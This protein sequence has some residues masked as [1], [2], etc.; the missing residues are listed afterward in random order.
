M[1]TL[2]ERTSIHWLGGFGGMLPWGN[3]VKFE[4]L[5]GWK[6]IRNFS[7][8]T[9]LQ[10]DQYHNKDRHDGSETEKF[11]RYMTPPK[12]ANYLKVAR[13]KLPTSG[14]WPPHQNRP[15][16]LT[17]NKRPAPYFVLKIRHFCHRSGPCCFQTPNKFSGLFSIILIF[18][19]NIRI[20]LFW[21]ICT[22]L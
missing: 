13:H 14:K 4:P 12:D 6:C 5:N 8:V 10:F 22:V 11:P 17:G 3:F 16:P 21:I 1:G 20:L 15:P 9:R 18:M 2:D 19:F 7:K